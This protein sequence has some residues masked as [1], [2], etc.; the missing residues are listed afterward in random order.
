MTR[1]ITTNPRIPRVRTTRIARDWVICVNGSPSRGNYPKN[2]GFIQ[3]QGER[4]VIFVQHGCYP[5]KD[6]IGD[7]VNATARWLS[8]A[9]F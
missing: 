9:Y 7:V 5:E 3:M 8:R 1:P 6:S 2:K 4:S